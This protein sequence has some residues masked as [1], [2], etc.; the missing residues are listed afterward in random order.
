MKKLSRR[1]VSK[2]VFRTKEHKAKVPKIVTRQGFSSFQCER[3]RTCRLKW[4]QISRSWKLLHT[5][6]KIEFVRLG[7]KNHSY[8]NRFLSLFQSSLSQCPS[9]SNHIELTN[10]EISFATVNRTDLRIYAKLPHIY[11]PN[12]KIR[13]SSVLTQAVLPRL[14]SSTHRRYIPCWRQRLSLT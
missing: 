8:L 4:C 5:K 14:H 3:S 13:S 1:P 6:T 10:L 11:S 7:K 9:D 2:P 12:S